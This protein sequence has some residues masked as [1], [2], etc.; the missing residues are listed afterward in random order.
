[1]IGEDE[2]GRF[3]MEMMRARGVEID[4]VRVLPGAQTSASVLLVDSAGNRPALHVRGVNSRATWEQLDLRRLTGASWVH[5]G[6]LDAMTGLDRDRAIELLS[7]L[8]AGGATVTVDFQSSAAHLTPDL[9]R[10]AA[11]ADVFLPNDEQAMG[12]TGADSA[13]IAAERLLAAGVPAVAV[14]CGAEGILYLSA[15]ETLRV[16]AVPTT[17]VDTTGCG[18]SVVAAFLVARSEG[19][20]LGD[21]LRLCAAAGSAVASGAGSLGALP[22]W[23]T[24]LKRVG[25]TPIT[26]PTEAHT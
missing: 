14:T 20:D 21:T 5:L 13:D 16:P 22:D 7:E 4:G 17:V 26:Q 18:D 25:L 8:R 9:I 11:A 3:L 19:R 10:I 2:T 15:T 24:L 6:G 23:D 12:L 1:M